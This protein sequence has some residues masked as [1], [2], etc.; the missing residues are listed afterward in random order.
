MTTQNKNDQWVRAGHQ[1]WCEVRLADNKFAFKL[2]RP[3][4]QLFDNFQD[5]CDFNA[6]L[7][8][9]DWGHRPLYLGLTGGMD[10]ECAADT[11]LRNN[12]PFTPFI[13]DL[14]D[15][16]AYEVWYAKYWCWKNKVT[17]LI[18]QFTQDQVA[19]MHQDYKH[20]I[21]QTTQH[22]CVVHT[23]M[24]DQVKSMGGHCV[25]S[26]GDL[27]MHDTEKYFYTNIVDYTANV[28]GNNEHPSAFF[29]YTPEIVLSYVSQFDLELDWQYNKCQFYGCVHRPKAD[30]LRPLWYSPRF[31]AMMQVTQGL[32]PKTKPHVF[33]TKQQTID[34]FLGNNDSTITA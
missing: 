21:T 6:K 13:L 10:S 9:Q 32:L 2:L 1:D 11:L 25:L 7:L 15:L 22:G 4:A 34:F 33:G 27:Y 5:A 31:K 19:G 23:Y 20:V 26:V 16:N 18:Q 29:A 3:A 14:G 24:F 8:Y 30:Y 17:P 28:F 12:I